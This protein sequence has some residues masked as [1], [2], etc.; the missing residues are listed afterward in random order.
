MASLSVSEPFAKFRQ[1][2]LETIEQ[3]STGPADR[4]DS[5]SLYIKAEITEIVEWIFILL[6]FV[7]IST[8]IWLACK[9]YS[10][11]NSNKSHDNKPKEI[12]PM[13]L[14]SGNSSAYDEEDHT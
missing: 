7:G 11:Q 2:F 13:V 10:N 9:K 5:E 3:N 12:I 8:A 4:H 1:R 6:S 14:L